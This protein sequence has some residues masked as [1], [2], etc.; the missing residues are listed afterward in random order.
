[1]ISWINQRIEPQ[2][3]KGGGGPQRNEGRIE[4]VKLNMPPIKGMSDPKTYLEWCN[5]P[6]GYYEFLNN[7]IEIILI[8]H[9][10]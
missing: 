4:G 3:G 5:I 10:I 7:K 8:P 1:M 6:T 2:Q 9:L